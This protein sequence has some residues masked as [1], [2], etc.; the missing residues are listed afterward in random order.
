MT[1]YEILTKEIMTI[2]SSPN[3]WVIMGVVYTLN[4][5]RILIVYGGYDKLDKNMRY[6]FGCWAHAAIY[7]FLASYLIRLIT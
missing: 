7:A 4:L 6:R 2:I 5:F 3:T 1:L